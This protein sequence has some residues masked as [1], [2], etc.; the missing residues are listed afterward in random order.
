MNIEEKILFFTPVFYS[1]IDIKKIDA[2][3][4]SIKEKETKF[5]STSQSNIGGWQS[6]MFKEVDLIYQETLNQ[7]YSVM[8]K[9]YEKYQTKYPP[10]LRQYW[11]NINRK[12]NYNFPHTHLNENFSG[13][14]YLKVP[15]NS[16]NLN[17][18][19]PL[20]STNL[21]VKEYNN[22]TFNS[23]YFTPNVGDLFVFQSTLFHSVDENNTIDNDDERIS[24]AFD[25]Y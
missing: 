18:F 21:Q 24:M 11:F 6:P 23:Y 1:R 22:Y 12:G 17:F 2:L 13:V 5:P 25:F 10:K 19:N 4:K 14:L 15:S 20:E 3:I 16:G 9:I 7:V 8:I